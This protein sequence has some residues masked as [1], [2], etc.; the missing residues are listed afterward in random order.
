MHFLSNR[1]KDL[2][3]GSGWNL[4]AENHNRV[5][6]VT[7]VIGSP[8]VAL[9]HES[10]SIARSTLNQLYSA[11]HLYLLFLLSYFRSQMQCGFTKNK[12]FTLNI[13]G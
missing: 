9:L 10:S 1:E 3:L 12:A 5:P 13:V 2:S 6:A 11:T 7:S 8:F 4:R